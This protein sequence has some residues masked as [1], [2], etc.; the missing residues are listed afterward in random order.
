[1][2]ASRP[3]R[4]SPTSVDPASGT[5]TPDTPGD[6]CRVGQPRPDIGSDRPGH[7]LCHHRRAREMGCAPTSE[8]PGRAGHDPD[9]NPKP[10]GRPRRNGP[11]PRRRGGQRLSYR[12]HSQVSPQ[13]TNPAHL[14]HRPPAHRPCLPAGLDPF[15]AKAFAGQRH[16]IE[17]VEPTI[18]PTS[19]PPAD[20]ARGKSRPPLLPAIRPRAPIRKRGARDL[21]AAP[22]V[23]SSPACACV[24]R[25]VQIGP[26]E[27]FRPLGPLGEHFLL[28]PNGLIAA[29]F[30]A[31]GAPSATPLRPA[32]PPRYGTGTYVAVV[33]G[34]DVPRARLR[35]AERSAESSHEGPDEPPIRRPARMREGRS[36]CRRRIPGDTQPQTVLCRHRLR[37]E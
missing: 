10:L 4:A 25:W 9:S 3:H 37:G 12:L 36:G 23:A 21:V 33:T 8:G 35:R 6:P 18:D 29:G 17:R 34:V 31:S 19:A 30:R 1:M 15:I 7:A 5:R 2:D 20:D 13:T 27:Y 32:R 14:P 24:A 26:H 16:P 11:C 28:R 22:R